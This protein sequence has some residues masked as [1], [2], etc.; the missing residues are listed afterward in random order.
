MDHEQDWQ[1][2]PYP[3]DPSS[4]I[5]DDQ[6]STYGVNK[7]I[8]SPG[9]PPVHGLKYK[10]WTNGVALMKIKRQWPKTGAPGVFLAKNGCT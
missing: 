2:E 10:S 5:Y 8:F 7:G 6:R 4:A 9:G 3:V 1:S